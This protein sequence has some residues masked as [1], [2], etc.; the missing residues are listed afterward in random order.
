MPTDVVPA[1]G[2]LLRRVT[3]LEA[4]AIGTTRLVAEL[5]GRVLALEARLDLADARADASES[6][7]ERVAA[8]LDTLTQAQCETLDGLRQVRA[9]MQ[10]WD[11]AEAPRRRRTH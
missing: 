5:T 2:D 1:L 8:A 4:Q 9:E 6:W 7:L 3:I 10:V 11:E